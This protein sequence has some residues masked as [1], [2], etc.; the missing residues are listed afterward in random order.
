MTPPGNKFSER[1]KV[2]L[3]SKIMTWV[4]NLC[5]YRGCFSKFHSREEQQEAALL[6]SGAIRKAE[7][8]PISAFNTTVLLEA[9]YPIACSF[10]YLLYK[11]NRKKWNFLYL[12]FPSFFCPFAGPKSWERQ[13]LKGHHVSQA[14]ENDS[15][16]NSWSWLQSWDI[17]GVIKFQ[18]LAGKWQLDREQHRMSVL[19]KKEVVYLPIT[20]QSLT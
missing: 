6:S 12:V 5:A 16:T 2:A 18:S 10:F 15:G 20:E 7:K 8:S 19:W 1:G 4:K 13:W 11:I 9:I 17:Y 3:L 14:F